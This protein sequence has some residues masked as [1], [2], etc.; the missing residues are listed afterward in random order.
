MNIV[1]VR[2]FSESTGQLSPREYSYFANEPLAVGDVVMVPVRS[3]NADFPTDEIVKA[4]V[5]TVNVPESEIAAFRDRVKTVLKKT[6]VFNPASA[7]QKPED[8]FG[9]SFLEP[10]AA[11]EE[12]GPF[13]PGMNDGEIN[14]EGGDFVEPPA[15]DKPV[16]GPRRCSVEHL[17]DYPECFEECEK[18]ECDGEPYTRPPVETPVPTEGQ[19]AEQLWAESHPEDAALPLPSALVILDKEVDPLTSAMNPELVTAAREAGRLLEIARGRTITSNA[20]LKPATDDLAIIRNGVKLVQEIRKKILAPFR[21]KVDAINNAFGQILKP[22]EDADALTTGKIKTFDQVQR[23]KTAEAKRI[24]DEK[25]KLAQDEAALKDGE[26]TVDLK[27]VPAPPPVPERVRTDLGTLGGRDNWKARVVD[28]KLLPD[29]YKLPDMTTLNAKARSTKG[30]AV[31]PGVEFYN[32]R[33][34]VVRTKN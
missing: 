12:P 6:V 23:A 29:E 25:L 21:A 7:G 19:Y 31:I 4:Q 27:P 17:R 13:P 26:I 30:T 34:V 24:E 14:E 2:Y 20:D 5:S 8:D 32:D 1:K 16:Q 3:R 9:E 18:D 33:S 11:E 15:A 10:P 22:L 28:M